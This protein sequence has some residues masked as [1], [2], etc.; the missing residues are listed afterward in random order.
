M[1]KQANKPL[2]KKFILFLVAIGIAIPITLLL[3]T[4]VFPKADVLEAQENLYN[5][6]NN[7]EVQEFDDSLTTALN[8]FEGLEYSSS[9]SSTEYDIN[10]YN[11]ICYY[12]SLYVNFKSFHELYIEKSFNVKDMNDYSKKLSDLKK[13]DNI[14]KEKM[15]TLDNYLDTQ[16]R[17]YKNLDNQTPAI[18]K[19]YYNN[20]I[21]KLEVYQKAYG[22]Y[23]NVTLSIVNDCTESKISDNKLEKAYRE[24]YFTYINSVNA[25]LINSESKVIENKRQKKLF[26]LLTDKK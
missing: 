3:M 2:L 21:S 18:T 17:V 26:Q 10:N 14:L 8:F 16:I 1:A 7:S 20:F 11:L 22:D 6:Y 19:S 4:Y 9:E 24:I 23:L 15:N 5:H 13:K 12:E 25:Y